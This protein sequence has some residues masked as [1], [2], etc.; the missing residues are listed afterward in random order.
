MLLARESLR[1]SMVTLRAY[2]EK[3]IAGLSSRVRPTDIDIFT[4]TG[5]RFALRCTVVYASAGQLLNA[6]MSS[7]C[8]AARRSRS[9]A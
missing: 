6:G 1:T 7:L 4:S 8:H 9:S 3:Y 5:D 2:L